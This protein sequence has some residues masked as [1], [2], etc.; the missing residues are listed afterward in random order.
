MRLRPFLD[1]AQLELGWWVEISTT[2]PDCTYYFGP[3][4][5]ERTAR[6]SQGGYIE[7]LEKEGAT[8][9]VAGVKKCQPRQLT[10]EA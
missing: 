8:G 9:I 5:S 6:S 10:I 2:L 1:Y 4:E 3:F 7:D